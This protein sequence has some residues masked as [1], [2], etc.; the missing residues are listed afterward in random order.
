MQNKETTRK[1]RP[2]WLRVRVQNTEQTQFIEKLL[3][4]LNL[5]TVCTEAN[6]PNRYECYASGTAT[7][8]ILGAECTRNC[9]YCNVHKGTPTPVDPDEPRH[10]A[11]AVLEMKLKHIVITSVTRDDLADGGANH[12]A[13]VIS[14]IRELTPNVTIEVL[15]P[16]F[17]GN[18]AA[19]QS[20][21]DAKPEI[22]NHN[23][24]TVPRVYSIVRPMADY[25]QSLELLQRVKE[26]DSSILTKS[27]IMVGLG[28]TPSEMEET[29]RDLRATGCE[30]LTIG[31][32]L[33]PSKEHYP[34]QEYITPEQFEAYKLAAEEMGFTAVASAPLVRSSY[35]AH[36][37]FDGA[38]DSE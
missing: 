11:E 17:Q 5:N 28:E 20:V 15:I 23:I 35:H 3:K 29:F 6:C 1:S 37:L 26:M 21:V 32:Y 27:G 38:K 9:R 36:E 18:R 16:D 30:L 13:Q 2:D 22:I 24:E 14:Q 8:M 33:A 31:Q 25:N 10:V 19:L 7:F 4:R 12:F 34:I